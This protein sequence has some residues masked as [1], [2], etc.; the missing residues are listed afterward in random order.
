MGALTLSVTLEDVVLGAWEELAVLGSATC[1]VCEG[2]LEPCE[3]DHVR[4]TAGR[5]RDCGTVLS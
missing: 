4:P 2:E 3:E 1:P 5:C